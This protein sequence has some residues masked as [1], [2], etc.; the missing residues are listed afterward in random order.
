VRRGTIG[1]LRVLH[2]WLGLLLAVIVCAV[3]ASGGLL[4]LRD[5]YYRVVYPTLQHPITSETAAGRAEILTRLESRWHTEGIRLVKFPRPGVN[6]FQVWLG[7]GS[8]AFVDPQ[9]GALIDRWHWSDRLPAFLFE[10]HAHL[11]AEPN[12]TVV[13]GFAA[14][15]VVFMGLT[16]IVLWWPGRRAAFR[17]RGAI[18]RKSTPGELLR[19]HAA[20][21]AL[22]LL[23]I[24]AFAGT[25]AAIVFYEPTARVMSALLDTRAPEEP[26]ARVTPREAPGR[27]WAEI[28]AALDGTFPEGETVFYYPGTS[29]NARL[30]FRKRLPGEW[31]P[32][33]RSY[34][35]VDP[36]T[37]G[38][39]QAIDARMQG[40]GTRIMHA[41]YP[42]HAAKVGGLT[43][44][45]SGA[46]AALALTWLASG[47]A[48]SYLARRIVIRRSSPV[49]DARRVVSSAD[50]AK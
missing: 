9:T 4:L 50:C 39:V 16:G 12:G 19:S 33:G 3:A 31:H 10:L 17:L 15:L 20:V 13:N 28:L 1:F 35:L 41:M 49:T 14:L 43:M 38:V 26:S 44:V 11:L 36:Y 24:L 29:T 34:V 45:A 8:E 42:V 30:M 22:G 47:G 23:P 2:R 7:D 27:P 21:G 40:A 25:G 32:N 18:P 37:A 48:W 6:A 5:P 46:F